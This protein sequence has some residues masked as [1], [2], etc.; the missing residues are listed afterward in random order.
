M[1]FFYSVPGTSFRE[2]HE[3]KMKEL[4]FGGFECLSG[5]HETSWDNG[6]P[7]MKK[8]TR[9]CQLRG[10]PFSAPQ[11]DQL[12]IW[13]T[14]Q[15]PLSLVTSEWVNIRCPQDICF[16]TLMTNTCTSYPCML[17]LFC[18]VDGAPFRTLHDRC[19]LLPRW[20][21]CFYWWLEGIFARVYPSDPSGNLTWPIYRWFTDKNCWFS[22]AMYS[23]PLVN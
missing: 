10:F 2:V 16:A 6:F 7:N 5:I 18:L 1:I 14:F 20:D 23:Y 12:G 17:M 9:T 11:T 22:I 13:G 21:L 3:G 15:C 8:K 4:E 19:R